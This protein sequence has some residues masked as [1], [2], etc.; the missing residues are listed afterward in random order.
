MKKILYLKLRILFL[1]LFAS[2]S[3]LKAQKKGITIPYQTLYSINGWF[4]D[5]SQ[6]QYMDSIWPRVAASGV[7]Y[8]RIG[9]ISANFNPIYKWTNTTWAVSAINNA[10]LFKLIDTLHYYGIKPIIQV[11]YNPI[12]TSASTTYS[13]VSRADQSTIAANLVSMLKSKYG[14]GSRHIEYYIIANEPDNSIPGGNC[15]AGGFNYG[16]SSSYADTIAAYFKTFSRKMKAKDSSIT[17]IGPEFAGFGNDSNYVMNII[18]KKLAGNPNDSSSI[19]GTIGGSGPAAGKYLCDI[20]TFHHYLDS[21]SSQNSIIANLTYSNSLA[22][23]I[24]ATG[25]VQKG[26]VQMIKNNAPARNPS[27]LKIACTEFNLELDTTGK[28]NENTNWNAVING[29][30]SR[31]FIGAQWLTAQFAD[32]MGVADSNTTS[33]N[34]DPWNK[35]MIPWSVIEGDHKKGLGYL[36]GSSAYQGRKRPSYHHYKLLTDHFVGRY[37][38]GSSNNSKVKTF[39][40]AQ[41]PYGFKVMVMNMDSVN[42]Y[43]FRLFSDGG[44]G[45]VANYPLTLSFTLQ[46]DPA[47]TLTNTLY[48]SPLAPTDTITNALKKASTI[49]LYFDCYGNMVRRID[50]KKT[51]AYVNQYPHITQIGQNVVDA[52]MISCSLPG[53]IGG[54]INSNTS[55]YHQTVPI[56]SNITLGP[57][58]ALS[59]TNC[60]LVMSPGVSISGNRANS[61]TLKKCV[62]VGCEG[63]TWDKLVIGGT[64]L[65]SE[66]IYIDSCVIVNGATPVMVDKAGLTITNSFIFNGSTGVTIKRPHA[67]TITDN[68]IGMFDQSIHVYAGSNGYHSDIRGNYIAETDT[69]IKIESSA[70]DSLYINCNKIEFNHRGIKTDASTTMKDFGTATIGAGNRFTKHNSLTASDF[71]S[72]G[73]LAQPTYY[74]DPIFSTDFTSGVVNIPATQATNDETCPAI[75]VEACLPWPDI[76]VRELLKSPVDNFIVYPNPSNGTFNLTSRTSSGIYDLTIYDI[77]GREILKRKVNFSTEETVIFNLK[78]HGMYLVNLKNTKEQIT[79]KIIVQ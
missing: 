49:I 63:A 10:V 34:W 5:A 31:S 29:Y 19:M 21:N 47:L 71:I 39:A 12:C 4:L 52:S 11:G 61:I 54:S 23:K 72:F 32:A 37:H 77:T 44:T 25:G 36:S 9:G 78:V 6:P 30:D 48:S 74:Y 64:Y 50:Y 68:M 13:N 42:D 66:Y 27:N 1:L 14:L 56:T 75:L 2:S 26:I 67:F 53:G 58:A 65:N 22:R 46:L 3:F 70:Q 33:G 57:S 24:N 73:G 35:F 38:S 17:V 40:S 28:P 45:T 8:V 7:K 41:G 15:A 59:F 16:T 20:L 62:V 69:A 18:M 79:K 60:L 55:Y 51:D 43:N 76:G